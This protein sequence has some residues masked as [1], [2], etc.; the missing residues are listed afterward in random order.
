MNLET[1]MLKC[2]Y[3]NKMV[4]VFK[5][6]ISCMGVVIYINKTIYVAVLKDKDNNLLLPKGHLKNGET[7]I[8]AA[9]REVLEETQIK[10]NKENLICKIGEFNYFSDLENSDK[11]IQAYLFKIDKMQQI[12]PLEKENF[13]EGK[14]LT[15]EDAIDKINYQEQKDLLKKVKKNLITIFERK[16]DLYE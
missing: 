16:R 15:L 14:W 6:I 7:Y 2:Y 10:L 5:Q 1:K 11:N 9:I 13:I 8:E 12:I 4:K 3:S